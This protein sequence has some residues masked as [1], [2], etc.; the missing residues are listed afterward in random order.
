M[1]TAAL[2]EQLAR[3]YVPMS[4]LGCLVVSLAIRI[5][6][7]YDR[8]FTPLGVK[9]TSN[10][11]YYHMSLV[12]N[13]VY[14]FPHF[15]FYN[16]YLVH[17]GSTVIGSTHFFD[18]ILA[19]ITWVV[20]LG[21]PTQATVDIVGAYT[22]P[23]LAALLVIPVYLL[24][25]TIFGRWVGLVAAGMVAILPGEF[26]GRS[27]LGGA[28]HHVAETL[29]S[30]T[31]I[32][33]LVLAVRANTTL[34]RVAC[35]ALAGS[36]LGIYLL[37][38]AG[39]LLFALIIGLFLVI[40]MTIDHIRGR[41][42]THLAFLTS[43]MFLVALTVNYSVTLPLVV[44]MCLI[45]A[46]AAPIMLLALSQSLGRWPPVAF[47]VI[48]VATSA[49]FIGILNLL[50]PGFLTY[51]GMFL[52]TGSTAGTTME[53][54]SLLYPRGVFTTEIAWGNFTTSAIIAPAAL[55]IL[56]GSTIRS[57]YKDPTKL[58]LVIWSAVMIALTLYQRRYAYYAVV[59]VALLTAYLSCLLVRLSLPRD[60]SARVK[61]T[62]EGRLERATTRKRKQRLQRELEVTNRRTA[63]HRSGSGSYLYP[64]L[65]IIVV[66][67]ATIPANVTY[68][69]R[70]ASQAL[71][72]P[73]DAWQSALL[74]M[75]S[76]TP[77][78]FQG[79]DVYN[80]Y[81][82]FVREQL[83]PI[84]DYGVTSWWDYGYWT[85]RIAHRVP[86]ANP[87]QNPVAIAAV[88]DMFLVEGEGYRSLADQLDSKYVI[89]DNA[90]TTG[91]FYAV[92][93]WGKEDSHR[94]M[95]TYYILDGE[96]YKP[97][98]V[99]YTDY[100]DTLAVRLYNFDGE[101]TASEHPVVITFTDDKV[102]TAGT[103]HTSYQEALEYIDSLDTPNARIVGINPFASP[104][105]LDKVDDYELVYSS[106]DKM[107]GI[108][109][110]KIF[111]YVRSIE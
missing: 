106:E 109:E 74:W 5:V 93:S 102:L 48:L 49:G 73:T 97:V 37:T 99:L 43:G 98:N 34:R 66:A 12:D 60:T 21:S 57:G 64:A 94:Y 1:R 47:P 87:A 68:A 59:N 105:P 2:R 54:Q 75:R 38:W 95:D 15:S 44:L 84:P 46:S 32:L 67:L 110:V 61:A 80:D 86:S 85:T 96:V 111:E 53:L 19:L 58:L 83:P 30:T 10:D 72:A 103:Q 63:L 100:Y 6:P 28:D 3:Y 51:L 39:G 16:P 7:A 70:S 50:Y 91:K 69:T 27:I 79:E 25:N 17:P 20:G 52:P 65:V 81:V 13:M 4:L 71:F 55:L 62:I 76:N 23:V 22:P 101:A 18:H 33:F 108:P 26:L 89:L 42:L 92:A 107:N 82:P 31:A 14:N 35:T 90:T 78:P 11:A 41:P 24:G 77:E 9:F 36:A 45:I 29:F 8:V 104:V 88:A 40:Q 56:T